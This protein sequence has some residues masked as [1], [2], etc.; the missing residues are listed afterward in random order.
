MCYVPTDPRAAW[1][2]VTA[3]EVTGPES[4]QGGGQRGRGGTGGGSHAFPLEKWGSRGRNRQI[5]ERRKLGGGTFRGMSLLTHTCAPGPPQTPP[6]G[7]L[8]GATM[9]HAVVFVG[10]PVRPPASPTWT[11]HSRCVSRAAV[12]EERPGPHR[13]VPTSGQGTPARSPRPVPALGPDAGRAGSAA[14]PRRLVPR[15]RCRAL[16]RRPLLHRNAPAI[17]AGVRPPAP[18]A[19]LAPASFADQL[20]GLCSFIPVPGRPWLRVLC[21][22]I[23]ASSD[24]MTGASAARKKRT[25]RPFR[26][27]P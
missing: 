12:S 23:W 22:H 11:S 25:R 7:A 26:N 10:P 24:H 1:T 3:G 6:H 17:L 14:G 5:T 18:R 21:T 27:R 15:P 9:C 16:P 4:V 8:P 13:P 19:R 2:T 20:L